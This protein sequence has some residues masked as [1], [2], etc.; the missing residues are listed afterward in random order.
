MVMLRQCSPAECALETRNLNVKKVYDKKDLLNI[1]HS[2]YEA[3][4]RTS[5]KSKG[6][7]TCHVP[8]GKEGRRDGGKGRKTHGKNKGGTGNANRESEDSNEE[9]FP[10]HGGGPLQRQ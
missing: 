5:G 4:L 3:V 8:V 9:M 2:Q 6:S 10:M 7:T 1:V